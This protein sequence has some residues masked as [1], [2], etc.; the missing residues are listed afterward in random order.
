MTVTN[1]AMKNIGTEFKE[2]SVLL[3]RTYGIQQAKAHKLT[4]TTTTTTTVRT[5]NDSHELRNEEHRN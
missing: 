5:L 4:T 3:S 2:T 1:S